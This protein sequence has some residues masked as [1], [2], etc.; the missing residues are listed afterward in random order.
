[1]T[2]E[3]IF[4]SEDISVRSLN[5]CKYNDLNINAIVRYYIITIK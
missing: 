4:Y 3:E 2:I 1:M 5:V